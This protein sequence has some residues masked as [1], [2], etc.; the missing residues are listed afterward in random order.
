MVWTLLAFICPSACPRYR[1]CACDSDRALVGMQGVLSFVG[2][3][4]PVPVC[5]DIHAIPLFRWLWRQ[6]V[7]CLCECVLERL[8]T[9]DRSS[10]RACLSTGSVMAR[11][12]GSN[13]A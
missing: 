8:A 1:N 11:C 9:L 7:Y 4:C 5:S 10:R 12:W 6:R 3:Q 13:R 2:L